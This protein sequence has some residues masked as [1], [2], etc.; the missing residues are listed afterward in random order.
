MTLVLAI[1]SENSVVLA[2]DKRSF[3]IGTPSLHYNDN[4]IKIFQINDIVAVGGAGDGYD[5]KLIVD[6]V[7]AE[8]KI[9][10]MSFE[11]VLSLLSDKARQ[12]QAEW[13]TEENKMLMKLG[14][15]QKPQYGFLMVG[16]GYDKKTKI[17]SF[18]DTDHT[19]H[20]V[21]EQFCSIGITDICNYI[22]SEEYNEKM[23]LDDIKK[24]ATK[25]IEGT[26][27]ISTAVSNKFDLIE[28]EAK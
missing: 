15:I 2:S 13:Y 19:P 22:F 23:T 20:E 16:I 1:K 25:G 18:S 4:A 6:L 21:F 11:D 17:F 7:L 12:K 27:K 9:S 24:L 14:V 5:C 3:D 28:I 10:K 8:K 26:A